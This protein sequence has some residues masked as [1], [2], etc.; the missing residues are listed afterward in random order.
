MRFENFRLYRRIITALLVMVSLSG[1]TALE[2]LF[3]PKADL[4]PRWQTHDAE[5]SKFIDHRIWQAF[6]L[7][8]VKTGDDGI[9]RVQYGGITEHGERALNRYLDQMRHVSISTYNRT[10]QLAYWINVYNAATIAL[11]GKH[12][13][14]KSIRDIKIGSG[15]F[16]DNAWDHPVITVEGEKLSLNDIEHRILRPIWKDPRLHYALNCASLGCP[17]LM[18]VAYTAANTD[19]LLSEGAV[20]Y[21]NHQRGVD[22]GEQGLVLSKIYLWFEDDFGGSRKAVLEHLRTYAYADLG[23]I[24]DTKPEIADYAYDWSLNDHLPQ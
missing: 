15:L 22:A 6:L 12:Y 3:A 23:A 11:V 19:Q 7:L 16:S 2:G 5:A 17:N 4:W 18:P 1:F 21:I 10:E 20:A 13:P 24:L 8:R 9:N 14:V